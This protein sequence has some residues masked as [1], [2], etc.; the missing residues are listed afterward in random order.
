MKT[1]S[2]LML[3]ACAAGLQAQTPVEKSWTI[4][5]NAAKDKNADDRSRSI[6]ALG[7]ISGDA[8][9][10][11]LAIAAF[12][13]EKEEV[14]AAACDALG[15]MKAKEA[16]PELK[17]ALKDPATVVVFAAANALFT[18]GDPLA[19]QVYYAVLTGEKKSGDTLMESQMKMLKDPKALSKM[20]LE[21]GIGFI[22]FGGMAYSAFKMVKADSVSPVRAAAALK[23]ALDPDPKS[24]IALSNATKDPKWIVRAGVVDAIAKRNDP[25]LL[26]CLTPLL[27]D[28][29]DIVRY[30]AAAAIIHITK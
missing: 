4:L 30:N 14:R 18:M 23:I 12:K 3:L 11:S 24:G 1:R 22:P 27:E 25:A 16:E 15:E 26:P 10:R 8:R 20:G 9:A 7:V 6:Q 2:V 19:Y 28:E 29:N 13:D 21:A 5:S 17:A